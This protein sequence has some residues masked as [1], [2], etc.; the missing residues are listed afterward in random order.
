MARTIKFPC[1][2]NDWKQ[3]V[4]AWGCGQYLRPV[5][6]PVYK[7]SSLTSLRYNMPVCIFGWAFS[8]DIIVDRFVTLTLSSWMT[9]LGPGYFTNIS[10]LQYCCKQN[11][12]LVK[13]VPFVFI[14]VN[15]EF[16]LLNMIIG[17]VFF[18][19]KWMAFP[20]T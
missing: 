9:L 17:A 10:H 3:S 2:L 16:M 19:M 5:C 15:L 6:M 13:N 14:Y 11:L 7:L 18:L 4:C 1:W 20:L 12:I 8:D